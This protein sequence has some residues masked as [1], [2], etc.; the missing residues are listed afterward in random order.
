MVNYLLFFLETKCLAKYNI[1]N[2]VLNWPQNL[3][4]TV[5]KGKKQEKREDSSCFLFWIFGVFLIIIN[6]TGSKASNVSMPL[7]RTLLLFF[8]ILSLV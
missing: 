5:S 1:S 2:E 7:L 6:Q 3:K 4:T 8:L